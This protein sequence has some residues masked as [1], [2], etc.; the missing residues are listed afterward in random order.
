MGSMLQ[1]LRQEVTKLSDPKKAD[2]LQR[3]FKTGKGQYGEGDIFVGLVVP[4]SRSLAKKYKNLSLP[5]IA[6]MLDS[7]IHEE[8]IIALFILVNRFEQGDEKQKKELYT[9][10]LKKRKAVNNWDLVDLS[11][12][13]ILGF[14]L[15]DK[16]KQLLY[17]LATSKNLWER[18]IA[19]V[20]TYYFIRQQQFTDTLAIATLLLSDK[21]DLIHKAV[22][23]MLREV[24]KRDPKTLDRYLMEYYKKM[25]RT[26]LRYALEHYPP[27][28]REGYMKGIV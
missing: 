17:D 13:Q 8:R 12:S 6:T 11:A 4:Q 16:E 18:R 24:G 3:F 28:R 15:F 10:Y 27:R 26:M 22:G 14:Y 25:P 21:Q 19:I 23:W 9:F 20:S 7:K 5:D 1:Q 2:I